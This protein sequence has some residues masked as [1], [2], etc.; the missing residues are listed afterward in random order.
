MAASGPQFLVVDLGGTRVRS[1]V[2][3]VSGRLTG[4]L[5]EATDHRDAAESC[6][7]QI[8]DLARRSLELSGAPGVVA[9]SVS[10]PGPLDPRSGYVFSPP[11]MPGWGTVP[12]GPRLAKAL[13]LCVYVTND[14]NAGA[15]GEFMFGSGRGLDD[16]IYITVSTGV[17]GGVV[18]QGRLLQGSRGFA[19]EIGHMT[20]DRH[21]PVCNCGSVG[22]LE[23]LASGTAIGRIFQ[24]RLE[25]GETSIVQ[26]W[27]LGRWATAADIVRAADAGDPLATTVFSEAAEA[28]GLGVTTCLHLFNPAVVALG[29]GVSKAGSRLFDRV[30][31]VVD[32]HAME[33]F[34]R[35]VRIVPAELGE[36]VGLVG[37]A[38][39]AIS[40]IKSE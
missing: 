40:R 23:M 34:K 37:A 10:A 39:V 5:E 15:M 1:A 35:S 4:R 2:A 26:E 24:E 9:T 36:D 20:I 16:V 6:I 27:S 31:E 8:V 38:A 30:R 12:L 11:N 25:S 33:P 19:S 32:R 21:G 18:S 13:S 7:A 17:G 3:D 14:A 22:C 29:G 28:L